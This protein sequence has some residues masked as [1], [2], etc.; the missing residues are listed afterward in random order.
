MLQEANVHIVLGQV[1]ALSGSEKNV[2][3]RVQIPVPRGQMSIPGGKCPCSGGQKCAGPE[4]NVNVGRVRTKV[5]FSVRISVTSKLVQI[6]QDGP[7][8]Q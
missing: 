6:F 2:R 5:G 4:V 3:V 7:D 8:P 1:L